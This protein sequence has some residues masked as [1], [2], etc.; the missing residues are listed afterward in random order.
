MSQD[1]TN[2][3]CINCGYG[4]NDEPNVNLTEIRKFKFLANQKHNLIK[5]SRC[6]SEVLKNGN[7]CPKCGSDIIIASEKSGDD[8]ISNLEALYNKSVSEKYSPNFK[9]AYVIFLESYGKRFLKS[10]ERE[11]KITETDL[12]SQAIKDS[13]VSIASPLIAARKSTV[14][15]LKEIL[16]QHNLK[17]SG[18]KDDLIK[19]LGDNLTVEEL[20]EIF[21]EKS[22]ELSD[23]GR[24]FID[25]NDYILFYEENNNL[26]LAFTPNEFE[27]IFRDNNY[28]SK[29]E[30]C[31][32]I[33][34]KIN[35]KQTHDIYDVESLIVLNKELNNQFN[36]LD[37]YLQ[38]FI[39]SINSNMYYSNQDE[40][41]ALY[42]LL[43]SLSLDID[44]LKNR[45]HNVYI[46]FNL[47]EL[48]ISER[49]SFTFLLKLF[50]GTS[51]YEIEQEVNQKFF[52]FD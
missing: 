16:R 32:L 8:D 34:D 23:M 35:S 7:F 10:T 22:Y 2:K 21:P 11:Y 47:I 30:M 52:A 37:N 36:L 45:F 49:D 15:D 14:A 3:F 50:S 17:V 18:K 29:E 9:F 19:R 25:E 48:K 51:I 31:K 43:H 46:N 39:Y 33:I 41:N 42:S 12:N 28:S 20:E 26:K 6:D 4:F 13:F 27:N 1:K 44:D 24:Q 5:C 40:M 38:L